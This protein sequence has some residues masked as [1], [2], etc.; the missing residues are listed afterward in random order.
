[1]WMLPAVVEN[2]WELVAV[3]TMV[4][5]EERWWMIVVKYHGQRVMR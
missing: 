2:S 1:M 3:M 5:N 4:V